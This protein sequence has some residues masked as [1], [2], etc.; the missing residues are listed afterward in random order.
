[1]ACDLVVDIYV[2]VIDA[3]SSGTS[4]GVGH[5][6]C[7][8][9]PPFISPVTPLAMPGRILE[10][11]AVF[12][13]GPEALFKFLAIAW[14]ENSEFYLSKLP[15]RDSPSISLDDIDKQ[16]ATLIPKEHLFP[17]WREDITEVPTPLPSDIFIKVNQGLITYNGTPDLVDL[18]NAEIDMMEML[19]K[20]PHPNICKYYGCIRDGDY[21]AGICL[22]KYQC[23]LQNIIEG[24]VPV[25]Q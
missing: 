14:T 4:H 17:L 21:V 6:R 22:R 23:T 1:M 12:G 24:E 18:I 2:I 16:E 9:F 11:G 25:D 8:R 10:K 5:F 20:E 15:R 13:D 7:Q 3:D 19:S